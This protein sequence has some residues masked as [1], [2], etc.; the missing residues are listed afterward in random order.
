MPRWESI[1]YLCTNCEYEEE[2]IIESQHRDE[3]T[4]CPKCREAMFRKI[5]ANITRASYPDGVRRKGWDDVR[6]QRA[7]DKEIRKLKIEKRINGISEKVENEITRC[8]KEK[9]KIG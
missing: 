1:I 2:D 8:K 9:K 3:P 7:I 6:D 5:T 4:T